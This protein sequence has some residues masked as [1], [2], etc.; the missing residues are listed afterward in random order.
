MPC[1]A[2]RT[3]DH[4]FPGAR[5]FADTPHPPMAQWQ[6]PMALV[7]PVLSALTEG[8]GSN[9]A[10]RLYGVSKNSSYRGQERLSGLQKPYWG[11]RAPTR[12]CHSSWK[13]MRGRRACTSRLPQMRHTAGPWCCWTGHAACCGRGHVGAR[14]ASSVNK[15][16]SAW[17]RSCSTQALGRSSRMAHGA[18]G[19]SCVRSVAP[20]SGLAREDGRRSPCAT[21]G[22]CGAKHQGAHRPK[23]GRKRPKEP[24][25]SPEH[26]DTAQPLATA[27]MHAH[28]LE[29]FPTARRRRCAAERRRTHP[30]AKNQTRLQERVDVYGMVPHCVRVHCT[31]RPVPAVA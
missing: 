13:G 31:T 11:V 12:F 17:A 6:T 19:V 1:G 24:T 9:A 26:P 14:N 3:L 5:S 18:L 27:E 30:S 4:G 29:A 21:A 10:T 25:P 8:G 16:W 7:V 15:P 23:R 2:P 28:Q 20:C 22:K